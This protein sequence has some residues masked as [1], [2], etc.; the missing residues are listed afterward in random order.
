MKPED[1]IATD[2]PLRPSVRVRINEALKRLHGLFGVIYADTGR[3]SISPGTRGLRE[4][5]LP[6]EITRRSCNSA[7]ADYMRKPLE[8]RVSRR[9]GTFSTA[10]QAMIRPKTRNTHVRALIAMEYFRP[11]GCFAR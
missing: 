2:H 10:C 6:V 7:A 5:T 11:L 3:A 8:Q 4:C 1:F 9:D